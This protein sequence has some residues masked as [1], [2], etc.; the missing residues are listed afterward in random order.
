M[1]SRELQ[2]TTYWLD[3]KNQVVCGCFRGT[4]Y[5]FV[6]RVEKI[7]GDKLHGVEYRKYIKIVKTIMEMEK[8]IPLIVKE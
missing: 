2:T 8:S 4:L 6:D 1:G 3:D 7:Y 5:E